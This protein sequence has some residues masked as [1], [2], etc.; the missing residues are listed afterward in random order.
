MKKYMITDEEYEAVKKARKKNRD[1]RIDKLLT[2]VEMR[3][4]KY[5]DREIGER[6]GWNRQSVSKIIKRF[7]TVGL[8]EYTRNRY[9]GN[10]RKLSRE[11]EADALEEVRELAE[12]G[13]CVG[14]KEIRKALEK[15]LGEESRTGYVYDVMRRH[16]WRKVKPRP[17][18]PEAASREEQDAAKREIGEKN[19][20]ITGGTS[21]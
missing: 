6:L 4:E 20:G 10:N 3:Y 9:G 15:K 13:Q 14:T 8:E 5:K 19:R 18:H 17:R 1:K 11:E 16:G 2:A 21:G 7:K 12:A